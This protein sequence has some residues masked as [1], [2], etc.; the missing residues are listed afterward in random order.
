MA[1]NFAALAVVLLGVLMLSAVVLHTRLAERQRQIDQ[2]EQQVEVQHELFD[3]LRQQRAVLRSPTRLASESL[4]LGMYA[5]PES[6]FVG[7][8]PWTVAQI[9]AATGST[10]VARRPARRWRR[11]RPG[12]PRACRRGPAMTVERP[13]RPPRRHGPRRPTGG[14]TTGAINRPST[15]PRRYGDDGV[16]SIG[17]AKAHRRLRRDEVHEQRREIKRTPSRPRRP[18]TRPQTMARRTIRTTRPSLVNRFGAGRPRPRLISTLVVLLLVLGAVLAKVGLMQGM[19]GETLRAQA[20]ELWTRTRQLSAQ[21]GTIFDRNGDELALSVPGS[22][23]AVNPRQVLDAPG[24]VDILGDLLGLSD[25]QRGALLT[26]M[27]SCDCGFLY[28]ARQADPQIGEQIASL[29]LVGVSV[30]DEDRRM[31]PGGNIGRSVIGRTDIDG[32]GTAGLERQYHA[33]LQGTPG[34]MTL[35]VAPGGQT[36]AGTGRVLQPATPGTDLVTTIDRSVQYQAEQVLVRQVGFTGAVGGQI[37]VMDTDTGDVIAMVSVDRN[38]QGVPVV[39]GGNFAAVGA[40]EPGSVGKVITLAGALEEGAVTP[41]TMFGYVPWEYD[42]TIDVGGVLHD[43]HQHDPL[44]LTTSGVLV[45]SSNVGTILVSKTIGYERLDHYMRAFGLGE[46]TALDV[47][48]RVAGHP[49]A[50]ERLDR[51]RALHRCLRPGRLVDPDPAGQCRQRDR[52]R[53]RVRRAATRLG[54]GRSGWRARRGRTV[55][56]TPGGQRADGD[57]DAVDD[58]RGRVQRHRRGGAGRRLVDRRQDRHRVQGAGRRHVLQRRRDHPR[59]LLQLRRLLP[60]RGSAGDRADL[61]RRA[62]DGLQL[63]RT[64]GGTDVPDARARRSSTSW[65][66]S[67]RPA[68]P[69]ATETERR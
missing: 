29:G 20:A 14:A 67:R 11:A 27:T 61:D 41:D 16:A 66:S 40:Y 6:H 15:K 53:R 47:P 5:P 54:D 28:V 58:A 42:C 43:S 60:G 33:L 19:G 69:I 10:G 21:R 62:E 59:L 39:S 57:A 9:I 13:D 18:A 48:G 8:D 17:E 68:R 45:E 37:I 24:T 31:M 3:V 51:H 25:E 36:I 46:R 50:V 49:Q 2:L 38:E 26:E 34:E 1:A 7:V 44:S 65:P 52:Q 63:R 56:D 64:V 30:D 32:N 22:T 35:E 55:G 23:V 4:R 12:P